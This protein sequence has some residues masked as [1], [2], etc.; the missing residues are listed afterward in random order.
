[1]ASQYELVN[2]QVA[3][4]KDIMQSTRFGLHDAAYRDFLRE[5]KALV[6]EQ[7]SKLNGIQTSESAS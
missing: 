4:V 2:T 5:L 3:S 6:W 1:M 7:E